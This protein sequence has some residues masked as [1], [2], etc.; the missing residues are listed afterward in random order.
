[1]DRAKHLQKGVLKILQNSQENTYAVVSF[2]I[3]DCNFIKK[4]TTTQMFSCYFSETFK[5]TFF[6]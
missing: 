2:L 4:E 5:D 1:M 6:S 3:K